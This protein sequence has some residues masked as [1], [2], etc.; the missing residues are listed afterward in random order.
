MPFVRRDAQGALL[1]LHRQAEG[2]ATEWLADN[3]AQVLSFLAQQADGFEQLDADFIRVLEDLIDVLVDRHV[4]NMTDLPPAARDKLAARRDH[5][6]P[7]PLAELNL[8]GDAPGDDNPAL[9]GFS[10]FA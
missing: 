6:R 2:G 8:L 4:I 5:R 7:S 1:S 9:R 10:P 3:D